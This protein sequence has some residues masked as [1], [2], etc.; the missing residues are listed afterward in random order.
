MPLTANGKVDTAALAERAAAEAATG[1][2]PPAD[3]VERRIADIWAELLGA[4]VTD[5]DANFFALGGTSLLAIRMITLLRTDLGEDPPTRAF[6]AA[7][8]LTALADLVRAARAQDVQTG[9]I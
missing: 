8:T 3:E 6:L 1:H 5:R 2:A 7:P 9:A 4:P